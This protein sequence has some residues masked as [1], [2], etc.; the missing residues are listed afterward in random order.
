M[1]RRFDLFDAAQIAIDRNELFDSAPGGMRVC[2][3]EAGEDR[4]SARV[5]YLRARAFEILNVVRAADGGESRM[6]YGE[7]CC[8]GLAIVNRVDFGVLENEVGFEQC[9]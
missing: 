7:G 6:F 4:H 5:D 8:A 9:R 3:D 1:N 2:I